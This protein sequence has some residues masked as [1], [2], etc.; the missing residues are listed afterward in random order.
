M[1]DNDTDEDW[2]EGLKHRERIFVLHYCTDERCF[3]NATASYR[4]TYTHKDR[5]SGDIVIPDQST[6]EANGSRLCKRDKVK[7][8]IRKL[9]KISQAELDEKNVYKI[10]ND[11]CTL[12]FFNPADILDKAGR[13]K[14]KNLSD[15]GE[16]AKAI[17]QIRPTQYGVHY[18]LQDRSKYLELLT[19][20]L[21][22]V[23][24][25]QQIE[26]KL[27]VIEMVQK[28]VDAEAWNAMSNEEE[29]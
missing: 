17:A 27:P 29:N 18:V 2:D 11:L 19:K 13:L 8:A 28:S 25:E 1:I 9:L 14:V 10:I 22:I 3:L 5:K 6:C 23:R 26:V 24:P 4:E 7:N 15:L 20:Y 16:K 21:D 12:A